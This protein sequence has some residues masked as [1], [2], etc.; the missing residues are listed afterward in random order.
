[1]PANPAIAQP[2]CAGWAALWP[3]TLGP[4]PGGPGWYRDALS[5]H[6]LSSSAEPDAVAHG[7]N[8]KAS[9]DGRRSSPTSTSES[10]RPAPEMEAGSEA[11]PAAPPGPTDSVESEWGDRDYKQSSR[12]SV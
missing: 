4:R 3:W 1:M 10:A 2:G 12:G 8:V 11:G 9:G 6:L 7:V 5:N